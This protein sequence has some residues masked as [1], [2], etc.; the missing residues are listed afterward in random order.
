MVSIPLYPVVD[1]FA[2]RH[3]DAPNARA[4]D[5]HTHAYT[6]KQTLADDDD[7]TQTKDTQLHTES[8]HGGSSR[9]SDAQNTHV[10]YDPYAI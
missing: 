1:P 7:A 2:A 5:K 4:H 6:L 8:Q 3:N 9:D 10:D